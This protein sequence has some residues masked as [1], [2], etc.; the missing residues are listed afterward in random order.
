MDFLDGEGKHAVLVVAGEVDSAQDYYLGSSWTEIESELN[1]DY[2]SDCGFDGSDFEHGSDC[3]S[4]WG[5][6]EIDD[7]GQSPLGDSRNDVGLVSGSTANA[8]LV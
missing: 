4:C 2:G 6:R 5:Y 7:H 3:G 1:H 8:L